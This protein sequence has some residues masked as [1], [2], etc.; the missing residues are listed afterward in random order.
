MIPATALTY[1]GVITFAT[2]AIEI[3]YTYGI[4]GIAFG[5]SSQRPV[6]AKDG[7]ALRVERVYRNQVESAAYVVPALDAAALTGMAAS[8]ICWV[9]IL[10]R[11]GFSLAYYTGIPFLRVPF[12]TMGSFESLIL[13]YQ[14]LTQGAV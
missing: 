9:I 13:I 5:F 12:F 14:V 10:G 4:R 6:V 2:I 8:T 1:F 11:A 3:F 7:L